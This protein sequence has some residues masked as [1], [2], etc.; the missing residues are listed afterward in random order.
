MESFETVMLEMY[1]S[2]YEKVKRTN[3]EGRVLRLE[4]VEQPGRD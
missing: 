4:T 3:T 1:V 2:E